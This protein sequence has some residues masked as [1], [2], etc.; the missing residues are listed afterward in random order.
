VS[1]YIQH[2]REPADQQEKMLLSIGWKFA[3][4]TL[5]EYPLSDDIRGY[6]TKYQALK[7]TEEYMLDVYCPMCGSC[8]EEGCCRPEKCKCFYSEHYNKTYRELLDEHERF[9][10]LLRALTDT[11]GEYSIADQIADA[12]DLLKELCYDAD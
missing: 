6:Y 10:I 12:T 11:T 7:V 9:L 5:F 8:G 2:K 1:N 3:G 4:F